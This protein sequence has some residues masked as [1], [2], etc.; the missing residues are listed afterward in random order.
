[1][2][3]GGASVS[4]PWSDAPPPPHGNAAWS[5]SAA[6]CAQNASES[7]Y[8]QRRSSLTEKSRKKGFAELREAQ[9]HEAQASR[10]WIHVFA[11]M[12]IAACAVVKY[13]SRTAP[14]TRFYYRAGLVFWRGGSKTDAPSSD[15]IRLERFRFAHG[16]TSGL[17]GIQ[18][19]SC[20][21]PV[22]GHSS[23]DQFSQSPDQLVKL[24]G[25]R[26]M[27]NIENGLE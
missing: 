6:F 21:P 13:T 9:V 23:S 15:R 18:A 26:K 16:G 3:A 25:S 5:A 2:A 7:E 24:N 27:T 8:R 19:P 22:R 20:G 4:E 10:P 12:N 14:S 17:L 1:M 11:A